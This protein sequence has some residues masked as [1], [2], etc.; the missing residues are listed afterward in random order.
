M[1]HD[2]SPSVLRVHRLA[3]HA[4]RIADLFPGPSLLP[5]ERDRGRFHAFGHPVQGSHGPQPD[6]GVVRPQTC[7]AGRVLLAGDAAH[8]FP[9][10]GSSL[11]I[12]LLD[13]INLGWKL[14]CEV[15]RQA[16]TRLLDTYHTERHPAAARALMHTRAQAALE[17]APGEDG[18]A[19]RALLT[20]LV[21][22]EE[23]LRHLGDMLNGSDIRYP[24][25]GGGTHP[26]VGRLVPDLPLTTP[27]GPTRVAEL[28]H[29]AKP[30]LL[31]LADRPDIRV[32]ALT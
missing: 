21:Q 23:P 27:A 20:E 5:G 9:A 3:G 2:R 8:L 16:P 32:S 28:L 30:I 17:H 14:A 26:L 31:N 13:T 25:P 29:T 24:M 18:M 22:L 10:G 6:G 11:N 1:E 4:E 15:H 7:R 19:L 12:G